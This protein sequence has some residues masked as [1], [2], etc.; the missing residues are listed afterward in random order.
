MIDLYFE[1]R[2]RICPFDIILENIPAQKKILDI[3]CGNGIV[4]KYYLK[5]LKYISYTGIDINK[6]N[7][8]KLNNLKTKKSLFLNKNIEEMIDDISK[9]DCILMIDVMHHLKINQ[10]K[11]NNRK[12]FI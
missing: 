9:Y 8:I 4:Y 2:K 6:R 7:I 12:Y 11:K 3:G 5:N 10:Q 1:I